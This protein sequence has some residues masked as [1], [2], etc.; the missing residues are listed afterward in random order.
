MS[1]PWEEH[2]QG[3]DEEPS[4]EGNEG[5]WKAFI[6]A[7]KLKN[8]QAAG[9]NRNLKA[10]LGLLTTLKPFLNTAQPQ[11]VDSEVPAALAVDP[12]N[13]LPQ[14]V[15]R[16]NEMDAGTIVQAPPG[17]TI[18]NPEHST[19]ASTSTTGDHLAWDDR[20]KESE[21][22]VPQHLVWSDSDDEEPHIVR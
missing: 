3:G 15:V 8:E 10:M 1:T 20:G 6:H 4:Q 12:R 22:D 11:Q 18:H 5:I 16:A 19:R 9:Q 7:A 21:D 13:V 2:K 17:L 14:N